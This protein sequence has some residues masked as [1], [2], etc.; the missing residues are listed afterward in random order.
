MKTLNQIADAVH[1]LAKEKG[2]HNFDENEGQFL[3]RAVANLHSEASELF[4]AYKTNQ[5]R[6]LCDK[7]DKMAAMGLPPLTCIEEEMADIVIRILDNARRLGVDIERA[8]EIKH[9]FNA[10]RPYRHGGK[11]A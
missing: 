3:T 2:W 8:V 6:S 10:G 9:R 5:L 7:S 11:L 4:E 1:E